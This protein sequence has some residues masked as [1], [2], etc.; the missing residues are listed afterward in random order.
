[1]WCVQQGT[2][3]RADTVNGQYSNVG[4]ATGLDMTTNPTSPVDVG[5]VVDPS[6]VYVPAPSSR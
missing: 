3:N 6:H 2:V 5:P 1:M 4:T